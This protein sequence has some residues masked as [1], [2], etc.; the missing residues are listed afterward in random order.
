MN[1]KSRAIKKYVTNSCLRKCNSTNE[2]GTV[3]RNFRS[4]FND[5]IPECQKFL[6]VMG[7]NMV[8]KKQSVRLK[9]KIKIYALRLSK[10][11]DN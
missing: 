8:K 6:P 11:G 2:S 9:Y 3:S 5:K 1:L 10:P 4:H 7:L